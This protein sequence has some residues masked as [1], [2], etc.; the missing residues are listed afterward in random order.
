MSSKGPIHAPLHGNAATLKL[1]AADALNQ[2]ELSAIRYPAPNPLTMSPAE[3]KADAGP[4]IGNLRPLAPPPNPLTM[5]PA[6]L[7]ADA[8]PLIG[9]LRPLARSVPKP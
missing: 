8:G 5:S 3:L 4:L 9:N 1:S 7:R 2:Q 6:E